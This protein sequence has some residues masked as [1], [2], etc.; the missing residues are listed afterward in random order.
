M[1]EQIADPFVSAISAA[2]KSG[3]Q[4]DGLTIG[5]LLA[6]AQLADTS[7][8]RCRVR[9]IIKQLIAQGKVQTL[10]GVRTNICGTRQVT[11]VFKFTE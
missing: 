1:S 11:S 7:Y 6:Q 4:E 3:P 10:R 8:Q 5:E 9:G 2:L